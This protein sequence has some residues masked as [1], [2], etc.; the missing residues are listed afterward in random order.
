[1]KNLDFAS[2]FAYWTCKTSEGETSIYVNLRNCIT[3]KRSAYCTLWSWVLLILSPEKRMGGDR[4]LSVKFIG[5][6][7]QN[8]SL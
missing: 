6:F 1:M 3:H 2:F 7:L 4:I 5:K 8:P